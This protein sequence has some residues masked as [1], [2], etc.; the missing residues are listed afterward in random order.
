MR[1]T[2]PLATLAALAA[3]LALSHTPRAQPAPT[4]SEQLVE[5]F[6]GVFGAHP[7]TRRS[8]ARGVCATGEWISTGA[9]AA[10][11]TAAS[12]RPGVRAEV[13]ARFSVGGGNP[14]APENAPSVRG[15]SLEIA[16]PGGETHGFVLIN[17]P[18]FTARTPESMLAF[19]RARAV[20]PQT[21]QPNAAAIAAANALHPDWQPQ[22]AYLRDTPPPASY[23]TAPYFGVNSFV[24]VNAAGQRQHARWTFEPVAGRVGLT[25]EERQARGPSFLNAELR[26]RVAAAP[27]EWRVLLQ[28]PAPGDPLNDAV[29]AWPADRPTV[30]VARLRI[31]GV[32]D[33]DSFGPCENGMFNPTLLPDGI[34]P[35]EDP[36]LTIRAEVY[37]VSLG[38][39]SR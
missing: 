3:L 25:P 36:V 1:A 4:L 19:L 38:R 2:A 16:L 37:A 9:G 10:L 35:S 20:D 13:T 18:V 7:G 23:A 30:E 27:A 12:L 8:G 14:M 29:T 31:T 5:A 21:R 15:L 34:E 11:S 28:L 24:F 17:T 39:R 33:A 32:A 22:I 6:E 26:R